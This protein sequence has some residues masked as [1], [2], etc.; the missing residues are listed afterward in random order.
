MRLQQFRDK[1]I[2]ARDE[3]GMGGRIDERLRLADSLEQKLRE[4][5][6]DWLLAADTFKE[7]INEDEVA[8]RGKT[9]LDRAVE[10]FTTAQQAGSELLPDIVAIT[11]W[12]SARIKT[13]VLGQRS[14]REAVS[15][16]H[17]MYLELKEAIGR[18]RELTDQRVR[19]NAQNAQ[20][21]PVSVFK[22]WEGTLADVRQ[23]FMSDPKNSKDPYAFWRVLREEVLAGGRVRGSLARVSDADAAYL[24]NVF[25]SREFEGQLNTLYGTIGRDRKAPDYV[26]KVR[27]AAWPLQSTMDR[28]LRGIREI[29]SGPLH[30]DERSA[31][32]YL[33]A[34][35]ILLQERLGKEVNFIITS[36]LARS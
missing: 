30:D 8:K 7:H 25:D 35:V 32:D 2:A 3:P 33:T 34:V 10:C 6:K 24:R 23:D 22:S 9:L 17:Q 11:R 14:R 19:E 31:R 28:Y 15:V 21:D 27:D 29:L 36:Q 18:S 13:I 12:V 1:W 16:P 5:L 20:E 4:P 26:L